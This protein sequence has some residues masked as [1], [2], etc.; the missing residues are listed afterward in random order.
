MIRV[1]QHVKISHDAPHTHYSVLLYPSCCY[2]GDPP[3]EAR[4]GHHR[5]RLLLRPDLV[6]SGAPQN[7]SNNSII[8]NRAQTS[9]FKPNIVHKSTSEIGI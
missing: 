5:D 3:D 1:L 7:L 6:S 2:Y 4:G 8:K 9:S